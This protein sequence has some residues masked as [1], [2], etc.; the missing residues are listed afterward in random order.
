MHT[1]EK[2]LSDLIPDDYYDQLL[3]FSVK[4]QHVK[5]VCEYYQFEN[6]DLTN[7]KIAVAGSGAIIEVANLVM[8]AMDQRKGNMQMQHAEMSFSA[9]IERL[10][11]QDTDIDHLRSAYVFLEQ[12]EDYLSLN[13][14]EE[15]KEAL[16]KVN[17]SATYAL[18]SSGTNNVDDLV[19]A[20]K[21]LILVDVFS[22][23]FTREGD[24]KL[25]PINNL[26]SW[27]RQNMI[28]HVASHLKRLVKILNKKNLPVDG[29]RKVLTLSY[30]S[31]DDEKLHETYDKCVMR[32]NLKTEIVDEDTIKVTLPALN[33]IPDAGGESLATLRFLGVD[34]TEKHA[35]GLYTEERQQDKFLKIGYFGVIYSLLLSKVDSEYGSSKF[36]EDDEMIDITIKEKKITDTSV[37]SKLEIYRDMTDMEFKGNHA[38]IWTPQDLRT[39]APGVECGDVTS[40]KCLALCYI[41]PRYTCYDLMMAMK[42]LKVTKSLYLS[43][44]SLPDNMMGRY[45]IEDRIANMWYH[46]DRFAAEMDQFLFIGSFDDPEAI[47]E[48]EDD[49]CDYEI[50]S[51]VI[52]AKK[53][54]LIN[55]KFS[56]FSELIKTVSYWYIASRKEN[57]CEEIGFKWNSANNMQEEVQELMEKIGWKKKEN[58]DPQYDM[59]IVK[60]RSVEWYEVWNII[61]Y[62]ACQIADTTSKNPEVSA[63][64]KAHDISSTFWNTLMENPQEYIVENEPDTRKMLEAYINLANSFGVQLEYQT[65]RNHIPLRFP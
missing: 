12:A 53:A 7:L 10:E 33:L 36:T 37:E 62:A 27:K 17:T 39:V 40:V 22:Q 56:K 16:G 32:V 24:L 63:S 38:E 55:I 30:Q 5:K 50:M 65:M 48:V 51:L 13:H 60:F 15:L 42:I 58:P 46:L 64:G 43:G 29:L 14:I 8:G 2:I 59:V 4:D 20:T 44:A 21:L 23:S 26:K 35:L 3:P 25:V 41:E 45:D 28:V 19:M 1:A 31:D 18:T 54:G 11:K 57:T 34:G 9:V 61:S 52:K 49:R 47:Y 6:S